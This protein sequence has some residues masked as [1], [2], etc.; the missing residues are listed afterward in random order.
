M[1]LLG[2][3]QQERLPVT[4]CL[5]CVR[6]PHFS[7]R[8]TTRETVFLI[9]PRTGNNGCHSG[10]TGEKLIHTHSERLRTLGL[11]SLVEPRLQKAV[12]YMEINVTLTVV[13]E[14]EKISKNENNISLSRKLKLYFNYYHWNFILVKII[15][16][17]QLRGNYKLSSV[18]KFFCFDH[19]ILNIFTVND[20]FNGRQKSWLFLIQELKCNKELIFK[21]L[22]Y[23]LSFQSWQL[24]E[25]GIRSPILQMR[26][27]NLR[28]HIAMSY[29]GSRAE[30][31]FKARSAWLM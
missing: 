15:F 27:W 2:Q 26:K 22:L 23:T 20:I 18:S 31:E 29:S 13:Q 3:K 11:N 25:L 7:R 4:E 6:V 1:W 28:S 14:L 24:C 5:L 8:T 16:N 12:R 10:C 30:L 9:L 17:L 21:R 19:C